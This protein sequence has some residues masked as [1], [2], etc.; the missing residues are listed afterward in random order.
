MSDISWS[1][2]VRAW[3]HGHEHS[4]V[5]I[6]MINNFDGRVQQRSFTSVDD[7]VAQLHLWLEELEDNVQSDGETE[8]ETKS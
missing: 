6:R 4:G 2:V 3:H 1:T 5:I 7:A 8:N